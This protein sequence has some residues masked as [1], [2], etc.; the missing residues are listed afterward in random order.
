MTDLDISGKSSV[1]EGLIGFAFPRN[2]GL[3]TRFCTQI[4]FR[5]GPASKISVSILAHDDAA[6]DRKEKMS[7]WHYDDVQEMTPARFGKI[8]QEVRLP[9][10]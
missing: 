6:K 1:L 5:R 3:C 2:S 8:L 4:V 10:Y 7:A 9:W